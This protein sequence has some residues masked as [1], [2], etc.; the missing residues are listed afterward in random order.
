MADA[1]GPGIVRAGQV[2]FGSWD[3]ARQDEVV[4]GTAWSG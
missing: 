1:M 3:E 2:G 4:R